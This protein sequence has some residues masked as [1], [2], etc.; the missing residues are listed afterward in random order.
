MDDP[1]V[2]PLM[3]ERIDGI[4]ATGYAV[5]DVQKAKLMPNGT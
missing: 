5:I 1:S 2:P 3:L 4:T